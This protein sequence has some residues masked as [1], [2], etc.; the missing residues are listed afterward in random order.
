MNNICLVIIPFSLKSNEE[1]ALHILDQ[2]PQSYK[3]DKDRLIDALEK[4]SFDSDE[5]DTIREKLSSINM[6]L[7]SNVYSGVGDKNQL[8]KCLN[9]QHQYLTSY[10]NI[11][12]MVKCRNCLKNRKF[13]I[14]DLKQ[15]AESKNITLV[16]KEYKSQNEVEWKCNKGHIW[17]ASPSVVKGTK[18]SKGTNCP[19]CFGKQ[20]TTIAVARELAIGRGHSC[21]STSIINRNSILTFECR[22]KT[23]EIHNW[24]SS[25]QSYKNSI[26]GCPFCT[27]RKKYSEQ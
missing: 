10:Y 25:F 16:S 23:G 6:T 12:R 27:G 19:K 22:N 14:D 3:K 15:I 9:C 24:E 13:T 20:T 7:Q 1:I 2:L 8:I 21:L 18:N 5:L 4:Y 11:K 17:K 26:N